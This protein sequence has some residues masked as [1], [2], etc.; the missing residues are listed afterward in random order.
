MTLKK[1][2]LNIISNQYSSA[3]VFSSV[4]KP[5]VFDSLNFCLMVCKRTSPDT[6]I[7]QD[8]Q[9]E[10][11]LKSFTVNRY[12]THC[13]Y[14]LYRCLNMINVDNSIDN[15]FKIYLL[16]EFSCFEYKVLFR[17]DKYINNIISNIP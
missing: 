14:V 15:L 2:V 11:I 16:S 3:D 4:R 8:N 10:K 1:T 7:L 12:I 5:L 6:Y 13:F 17:F 9:L